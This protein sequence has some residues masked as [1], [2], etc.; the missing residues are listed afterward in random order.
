MQ[1]VLF[2]CHSSYNS[3]A[4]VWSSLVEGCKYHPFNEFEWTSQK[5]DA[6]PGLNTATWVDTSIV[7]ARDEPYRIYCTEYC[8]NSHSQMLAEIYVTEV[9][10]E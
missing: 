8:G 7:S 2:M 10:S 6:V 5:Q 9:N 3:P 1:N 4:N